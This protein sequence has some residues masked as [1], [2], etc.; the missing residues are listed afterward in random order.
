MKL[1]KIIFI[2]IILGIV[3]IAGFYLYQKYHS[4]NNSTIKKICQDCQNKYNPFGFAGPSKPD[5][6]N[7]IQ[8]L[9]VKYARES[10]PWEM[11]EPFEN[12][13]NFDIFKESGNL[14]Q[15]GLELIARLKLGQIWATKCEKSI[16]CSKDKS[17]GCPSKSA[18]CP[19]KDLGDWSDKGYSPLLYDFIYKSLENTNK[20]SQN[21]EYLIVGNEVNTPVFWH[22]A[23]NDY[24]KTRATVYK[25]IKDIN[26]KNGTN[27]KVVDNGIASTIWG[28][29]LLRENYCTND[30]NKRNY[31]MD[32]AK[33]YF[34]LIY[35][36][37]YTEDALA[38]RINCDNPSQDYLMLKEIF[39]KDSNLNEASFDLMSYH[40]YEPW[41]TQEDIIQWIKDEM[42]KNG[43]GKPIMNTEGGY[44]DTLHLY[45]DTPTLKQDV[46]NEIPK[47][48]VVAFANDVKTWLWLPFTE[49]EGQFYG[50]EWK[51]LIAEDQK[52]LPA[53]FSYQ[54][55]VA[56]LSGFT[57]IEKLNQFKYAYVYRVDFSD[58]DPVYVIWADTN[59]QI[60]LRSEI[61]GNVQI[62]DVNQKIKTSNSSKID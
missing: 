31:A 17:F 62:T 54:I 19:P 9:G 52:A 20:N 1:I 56:K 13:F 55:M 24:L 27:Y 3:G 44:R 11:I 6:F 2:L 53:Y 51:G 43:Y 49:R 61:S 50:P 5:N 7:N 34:R 57:S 35:D 4:S 40:F 12:K 18:D 39:K 21:F 58:K 28:G 46:A 47:L 23:A 15:Y 38:K 30:Q 10:I 59:T 16:A 41:D 25:A 42:K 45:S 33:K 60:D 22:G 37:P 32:F 14:T 48:H 8:A 36:G 29:A 26:A